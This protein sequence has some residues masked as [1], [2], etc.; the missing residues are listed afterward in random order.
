MPQA[1]QTI[2]E[3]YVT[4]IDSVLRKNLARALPYHT[5]NTVYE[6]SIFPSGKL[7][8][9]LLSYMVA[10]DLGVD[11]IKSTNHHYFASFLEIHHTYTL[12]HDDLPCM[13][14]D[15]YRRDRL[16]THKKFGEWQA[17]LSA[18]GLINLSYQMLSMI[19][20][21]SQFNKLLKLATH[22][23]GPKGLILGQVLDLS[24]DTNKKLTFDEF[25]KI[26][27]LKTGRLFQ[28]SLVGSALATNKKIPLRTLKD[29]YR[30]G[31]HFGILF[32]LIDDLFDYHEQKHK[33]HELQINPFFLYEKNLIERKMTTELTKLKIALAHYKL[34]HLS[35]FIKMYLDIFSEKLKK[36]NESDIALLLQTF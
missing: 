18:D 35:A 27:E 17:L 10:I 16:T 36:L 31:H 1:I 24:I 14:D 3:H 7:I 2:T 28:L 30:M 23:L 4:H 29:L 22:T 33:A 21:D 6:Y 11:P 9:P 25:L 19:E 15:D 12:V 26:H 34:N 5:F 32:Q 20:L 13:D 8:R